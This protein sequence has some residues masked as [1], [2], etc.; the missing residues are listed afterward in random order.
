[1]P[2]C[3]KLTGT[4]C[5]LLTVL[6]SFIAGNQS[7]N[8]RLT[9]RA[10]ASQSLSSDFDTLWPD[11]LPVSSTIKVTNTCPDTPFLI[12]E[13][14]KCI[15]L[16]RISPKA[17]LPPINRAGCSTAVCEVSVLVTTQAAFEVVASLTDTPLRF[18]KS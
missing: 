12:V 7:V 1:M 18:V 14:G 17:V 2:S 16:A 9:R 4:N 8:K 11:G 6:P 10:S 3:L 15:F 13:A 5:K